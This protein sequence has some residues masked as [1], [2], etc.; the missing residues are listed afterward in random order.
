MNVEN[1]KIEIDDIIGKWF[2]MHLFTKDKEVYLANSSLFGNDAPNIL[3]RTLKWFATQSVGTK[4]LRWEEESQ[5]YIWIL[6]KKED[7]FNIEIWLGLGKLSL[8][9]F[10]EGEEVLKD[11]DKILFSATTSYYYFVQ[12]VKE[13]FH[14]YFDFK[15]EKNHE[16]EIDFRLL[17]SLKGY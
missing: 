15:E 1:V 2:F 9:M 5:S 16:Y 7:E 17:D 3:I 11:K 10:Y 14:T 12:N 4:Y 6:N 8:I 13:A